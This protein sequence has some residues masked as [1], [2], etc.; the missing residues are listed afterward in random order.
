MKVFLLAIARAR[1]FS[2]ATRISEVANPARRKK[3]MY[4]F[5]YGFVAS[6]HSEGGLTGASGSPRKAKVM[7][8]RRRLRW[9]AVDMG[10]EGGEMVGG[11]GKEGKGEKWEAHISI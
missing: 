1:S 10:W 3:Q 6:H 7:A 4:G 9:G 5:R 11:K 8:R 2:P